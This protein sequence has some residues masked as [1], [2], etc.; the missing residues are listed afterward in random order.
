MN[1]QKCQ[2]LVGDFLEGALGGR[3]RELLGRH[4]EECLECSEVRRDLEAILL[5]A[6][7]SADVLV[8]PPN[9]QA[10][11]LRIRNTVEAELEAQ[12][13]AERR[14]EAAARERAA[15]AG[16]WSRLM[17]KR[18]ELSLPQLAVSIAVLLLVVSVGTAFGL[19]GLTGGAELSG[20]EGAK[21]RSLTHNSFDA[22]ADALYHRSYLE[23]Q[24]AK[25]NYWRQRVEHRKANWSPQIRAAFERSVSV[26]DDTINQAV[27]ALERDPHDEVSQEILNATLRDKMEFLREFSDQ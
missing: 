22:A 7:E 11:W 2:D 9:P 15:S 25:I 17:G 18:W 3:D 23:Q 16:F 5:A 24:E 20:S 19:R 26:Y 14:A 1:C 12:R 10:M 8:S 4:L 6:R 27:S 21:G 13:A